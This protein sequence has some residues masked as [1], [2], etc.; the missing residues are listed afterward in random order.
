M[1]K[2]AKAAV[3]TVSTV[4][5]GAGLIAVGGKFFAEPI[6]PNSIVQKEVM[7]EIKVS[8][9]EK[10]VTAIPTAEASASGAVETG[11]M[12]VKTL[13]AEDIDLPKGSTAQKASLDDYR[14]LI[15]IVIACLQ[16]FSPCLPASL[17][18]RTE[19]RRTAFTYGQEFRTVGFAQKGRG[20]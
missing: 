1:K 8:A 20:V 2:S 11:V 10:V 4:A 5:L 6:A 13:S 7:P 18:V 19:K 9:P 12:H 17:P 3:M 15:K 14:M 16:C